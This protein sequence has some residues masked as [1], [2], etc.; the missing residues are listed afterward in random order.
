[1]RRILS[2]AAALT[3]TLMFAEALHAA[4]IR[5]F[6]VVGAMFSNGAIAYG[7]V[8]EDNNQTTGSIVGIDFFYQLGAKVD[9]FTMVGRQT[10][11]PPI[12]EYQ[13]QSRDGADYLD[14]QLPDL[15]PLGGYDSQGRRIAFM[16]G[17]LCSSVAYQCFGFYTEVISDLYFPDQQTATLTADRWFLRL[18]LRRLRNRRPWLW[19]P[20]AC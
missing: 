19:W 4:P 9:E 7:T 16:G 13:L 17:P 3:C 12:D 14:L 2:A 11:E 20:L 1:M 8:T 15:G 6:N 5:V 10:L 18:R